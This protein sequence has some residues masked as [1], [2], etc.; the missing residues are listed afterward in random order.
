MGKRIYVYDLH[1]LHEL[2]VMIQQYKDKTYFLKEKV[3]MDK[4]YGQ[5]ETGELSKDINNK[6]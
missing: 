4:E 1:I 5:R 6:K 2:R 3:S